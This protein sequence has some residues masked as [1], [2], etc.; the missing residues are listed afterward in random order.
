MFLFL[1]HP[2]INDRFQIVHRACPPVA[3]PATSNGRKHPLLLDSTFDSSISIQEERSNPKCHSLTLHVTRS[4]QN[5]QTSTLTLINT[6]LDDA[7]KITSNKRSYAVLA[8]TS[9]S[10]QNRFDQL[11]FAIERLFN[12]TP[13][14]LTQRNVT[15]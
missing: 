2:A 4:H 13:N 12:P 5:K 14:N 11:Q 3:A 7:L 8:L 6:M 1:F 15:S 10:F 9:P